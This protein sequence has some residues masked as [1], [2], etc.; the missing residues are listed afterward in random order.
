M[1]LSKT[2]QAL[3][4]AIDP[5]PGT[6]FQNKFELGANGGL[7]ITDGA[8]KIDQDGKKT[9]SAVS[10]ATTGGN[11]SGD[12]QVVLAGYFTG[13]D[14]DI[15]IFS[16]TSM[17]GSGTVDPVSLN[18][19]ITA[20]V[21][22]S[23]GKI[24]ANTWKFASDKLATYYTAASKPVS[25]LLKDV[26]SGTIQGNTIGYK[27]LGNVANSDDKSGV[28][29]DAAAHAATYA[30]AQQAAVAS[31]TTM[32]DAMFGRV[33]AVG[34]EAASISATGSQANGGVWLTPNV[35]VCRR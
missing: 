1:I 10:F 7:V 15:T 18:G 4:D 8:Y 17:T 12:G 6:T 31:V 29:A 34:V 14:K 16:G 11:V 27:F 21:E 22:L 26:M 35:Q 5:T 3:K 33:G 20:K 19:L 2:G 23:T 30:G 9:G 24:Q 32:A 25:D 13:A 28:L